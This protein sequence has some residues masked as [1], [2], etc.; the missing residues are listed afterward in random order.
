MGCGASKSEIE[1]EYELPSTSVENVPQNEASPSSPVKTTVE[2]KVAA[3]VQ[4]PA[5]V[6]VQAPK[7][8][9]VWV[10]KALA[11]AAIEDPAAQRDAARQLQADFE[12]AA[13]EAVNALPTVAPVN[14]TEGD[15]F[16]HEGIAIRDV[17]ND[18]T[19]T[20]TLHGLMGLAGTPSITPVPTAIVTIA[21]RR[22]LCSSATPEADELVAGSNTNGVAVMPPADATVAACLVDVARSLNL[23]PHPITTVTGTDADVPAR[24]FGLFAGPRGTFIPANPSAVLIRRDPALPATFRPE[25][26]S[27][28]GD[29]T[30]TR[31]GYQRHTSLEPVSCD[32]CKAVILEHE[33]LRGTIR[34]QELDV[35]LTCHRKGR[36][37]GFIPD[38]RLSRYTVP[39]AQREEYWLNPDTGD[40]CPTRPIQLIPLDAEGG[41]APTLLQTAQ[42]DALRALL[43]ALAA[44]EAVMHDADLLDALHARGLPLACLGAI[45]ENDVDLHAREVALRQIIGRCVRKFVLNDPAAPTP[46]DAE[47]IAGLMNDVLAADRPDSPAWRSITSR[48]QTHYGASITP[49]AIKALYP[50]A[51]LHAVAGLL[52]V[53][54][55]DSGVDF[56]AP[57]PVTA[58]CIVAIEPLVK[59]VTGVASTSND[60][61]DEALALDSKGIGATWHTTGG[62]P[63]AAATDLLR[64]AAGPD[65]SFLTRQAFADQLISR[66]CEN[67]RPEFSRWNR[68]AHVEPSPL[69]TEAETVLQA[70]SDDAKPRI[71]SECPD[72]MQAAVAHARAAEGLALIRNDHTLIDRALSRLEPAV[73]FQHPLVARLYAEL[74]TAYH[75][76]GDLD[77]ALDAG[78]R[79][80]VSAHYTFGAGHPTLA[81]IVR[82]FFTLETFAASGLDELPFAA[83]VSRI[84][85]SVDPEDL[86]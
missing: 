12:A 74:A 54:L 83:A 36:H 18:P 14:A 68:A 42:D 70:I 51:V 17:T 38:D 85:E 47:Y 22:Y 16:V 15:V 31:A 40:V 20:P 11:V 59:M 76:A 39:A 52:G 69:S 78:R 56:T 27:G 5:P 49:P 45:A 4:Q 61:V 2:K 9:D 50:R 25:L 66:H 63:R 48:A 44:G 13:L 57:A 29:P 1:A 46:I 67:G 32:I 34:G 62:P 53:R 55:A 33:H 72:Y 28:F 79:A 73:G 37:Q 19:A 43:A 82:Q 58:A 26:Q 41:R 30:V 75:E 81:T 10:N 21:P 77:A 80:A 23:A 6:K 64:T 24:A 7:R 84:E 65:A 86:A 71:K 8:V 35:C 3:E 60:A